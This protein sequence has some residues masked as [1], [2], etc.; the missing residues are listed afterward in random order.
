[1][2]DYQAI[3]RHILAQYTLPLDGF[4]GPVH[5]EANWFTSMMHASTSSTKPAD[6]TP[7]DKPKPMLASRPAGMQIVSIWAE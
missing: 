7:M 6:C 3:L 5:C 4:H 2:H 1:M